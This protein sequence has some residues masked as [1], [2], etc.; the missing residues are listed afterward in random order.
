MAHGREMGLRMQVGNLLSSD[1]FYNADDAVN[2]GWRDLGVLAVEM[3]SA[4]LY[5]NAAKSGK[6]AL[7]ICTISD[8]LYTDEH[9]SADERQT[10]FTQMMEL[11]LAVAVDM[12]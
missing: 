7:A 6:R 5:L 1:I 11:A 9:L 2:D 12:A 3:E 4:G 8:H 10:S